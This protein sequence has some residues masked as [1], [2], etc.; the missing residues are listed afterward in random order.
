MIA[1]KNTRCIDYKF[2]VLVNKDLC[3]Q[4]GGFPGVRDANA[5]A[6]ALDI[7]CMQIF[8]EPAYVGLALNAAKIIE[9][10][11]KGHVFTD[12]NKRTAWALAMFF[13]ASNGYLLDPEYP[14]EGRDA[15]V[16]FINNEMTMEELVEF[17]NSN[18]TE[19]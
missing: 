17:I 3:E 1:V 7:P 15:I 16:S 10:I 2:A 11:V 13:C 18:L 8:G 12:G 14:E 5:L 19:R 9:T 6:Y 4:Y